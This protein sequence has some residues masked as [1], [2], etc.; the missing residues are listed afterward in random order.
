MLIGYV[1]M[2]KISPKPRSRYLLSFSQETL[3]SLSQETLTRRLLKQ[4]ILTAIHGQHYQKLRITPDDLDGAFM[5]GI[6]GG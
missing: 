6:S 4:K 3:T 1:D 5:C 2:L